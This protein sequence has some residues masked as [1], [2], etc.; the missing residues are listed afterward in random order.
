MLPL[1][2]I[3][4]AAQC[5][6]KKQFVFILAGQSNMGGRAK[7]S[8]LPDTL[9]PLLDFPRNVSLY[10][11]KPR[12]HFFGPEVSLIQELSHIHSDKKCIFIKFAD[13]GSSLLTWDP[14]WNPEKARITKSK[15]RGPIY[16]DFI[17]FVHNNSKG[18]NVQFEAIFWMQGERDAIFPEAG[19][20]YM[21]NFKKLVGR[22]RRDLNAPDLPI[23]C[24]QINPPPDRFP[25][26]EV[27]REAQTLAAEKI[28]KLK[29]IS[30]DGLGKKM[31]Q[32][33][34][35]FGGQI[36]LGR[37]FAKA[38]KKMIEQTLIIEKR[39]SR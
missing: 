27:V 31:D 22:I 14:D 13:H 32:I 35:N 16:Q 34:Y 29:L 3:S 38:Y 9:R 15:K 7:I 8:K 19:R 23:F 10:D 30:T 20:L 5:E 21:E 17:E 1:I 36:E 26:V 24:G 28:P 2:L 25:A 37:R 11:Y 33:H 4:C 18:K 6:Q 12:R 39:N